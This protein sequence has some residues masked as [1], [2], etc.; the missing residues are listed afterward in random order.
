MDE[1]SNAECI[2][3]NSGAIGVTYSY[4]LTKRTTYTS[5][6]ISIIITSSASG[7]V[8]IRAVC[9][10][11]DSSQTGVFYIAGASISEG[12]VESD[13]VSPVTRI[14]NSPLITNPYLSS[15][16]LPFIASNSTV[17]IASS[18]DFATGVSSR[19]ISGGSFQG[20]IY[21]I[22]EL[23]PEQTYSLLSVVKRI[24]EFGQPEIFIIEGERDN[25]AGIAE[26]VYPNNKYDFSLISSHIKPS[27]AG[28]IKALIRTN[29][30]GNFQF[31]ID[32]IQLYSGIRNTM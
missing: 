29:S 4:C 18:N 5:D 21:E 24:P 3:I 6:T 7:E 16:Q 23:N 10:M 9:K 19:L 11:K 20:V 30:S 1:N 8:E 15:S 25:T 31:I 17:T 28:V 22:S 27:S 14:D 12:F 26:S 2:Q 32:S 13:F